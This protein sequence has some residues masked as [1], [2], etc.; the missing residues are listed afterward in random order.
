MTQL[1]IVRHGNTFSP[2]ETLTRVGA[3]TDLPLVESGLAQARAL[4][5]HFRGKDIIPDEVY[6]SELQR[7]RQTAATILAEMN[8][9]LPLQTSAIFNEID[10]GPD[11]NKPEEEVIARLGHEALKKWDEE[12][13]VPL[14]WDFNPEQAIADWQGF[15]A[16]M[17]EMAPGRTVMVVTSNGMARFA[18]YLTGDFK[19]FCHDFRIKL[20]TGSYG[21]LSYHDGI[22]RPVCWGMKP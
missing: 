3:R 12:A 14:G 10:Y 22:W 20:G 19:R 15:A 11:E 8:L 18:P 21:L 9:D 2:G 17:V 13:V 1:L 4:G 5:R 7:T 6:V 16:R